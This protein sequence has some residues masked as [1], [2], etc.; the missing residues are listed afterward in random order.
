MAKDPAV[1]LYV[2]DFLVGT[3]LLNALQKGHYITL[4]CYQQ[5]SPTGSLKPEQVK[6]LMGRDYAKNWPVIA[7]KFNQ[8]NNGFYNE[9]MRLEIERRQKNSVRQSDRAKERWDKKNGCHGIAENNATAMQSAGNAFLETAI[10][11]ETKGGARKWKTKPDESF[12]DLE[13]PEIKQGAVIELF[14]ITKNKAVSKVQVLGLWSIFKQQNFTGEKY[15]S[16]ENEAYS[17]F[18]N[19]VKSQKIEDIKAKSF[20]NTPTVQLRKL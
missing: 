16:S 20:E 15:Y 10:E 1:L 13:L 19:W 2:Q 4:L 3:S 6:I 9:R 5:Q 8:D 11:T 18:I 14:S 17:H 12:I 7:P